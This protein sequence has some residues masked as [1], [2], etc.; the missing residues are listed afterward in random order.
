MK[1]TLKI[2]LK[3]LIRIQC[4]RCKTYDNKTVTKNVISFYYIA[5]KIVSINTLP[6]RN[7]CNYLRV[8]SISYLVSFIIYQL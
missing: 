3:M 4:T 7:Y 5:R 1:D 6:S 8:L 2:N